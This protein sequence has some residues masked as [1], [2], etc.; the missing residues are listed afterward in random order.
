MIVPLSTANLRNAGVYSV[1]ER[2]PQQQRVRT[3]VTVKHTSLYGYEKVEKKKKLS[4]MHL[5]CG[6]PA[7]HNKL[8]VRP[9][10]IQVE[11][12]HPCRRLQQGRG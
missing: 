7:Y 4:K 2:A 8:R 3:S 10:V 6:T 12:H 1:G 11:P 9:K 5:K